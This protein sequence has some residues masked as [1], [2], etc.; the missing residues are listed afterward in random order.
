MAA[1]LAAPS[2]LSLALPLLVV[3]APTLGPTLRPSKQLFL[4]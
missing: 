4:E 2:T 1:A 3:L